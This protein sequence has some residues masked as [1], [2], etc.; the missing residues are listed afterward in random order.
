M[1]ELK[2][3]KY[4]YDKLMSLNYV[5]STYGHIS[6]VKDIF[7]LNGELVKVVLNKEH[8]EKIVML[9]DKLLEDYGNRIEECIKVIKENPSLTKR[10]YSN[11]CSTPLKDLL[12]NAYRKELNKKEYYDVILYNEQ[13]ECLEIT[14]YW[15]TA[16]MFVNEMDV[17]Y[18][19][20]SSGACNPREYLEES[21]ERFIEEFVTCFDIFYKVVM[22]FK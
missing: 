16:K 12:L 9:E 8:E 1:K 20:G 14:H 13:I 10:Y 19:E 2:L 15:C 3:Y 22:Q 11:G 6:K 17:W 21:K 18:A 4:E 7:I 5:N